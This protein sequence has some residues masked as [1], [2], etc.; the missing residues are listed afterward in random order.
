MVDGMIRNVIWDTTMN[1]VMNGIMDGFINVMMSEACAAQLIPMLR[2][3][4]ISMELPRTL[5]KLVSSWP[6]IPISVL[7]GTYRHHRPA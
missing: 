1:V 7:S 6:S 2:V 5:A 4:Y 3:I